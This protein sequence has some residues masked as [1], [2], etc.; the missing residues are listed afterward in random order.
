MSDAQGAEGIL[1]TLIG[2]TDAER[3]RLLAVGGRS[4]QSL[5]ARLEL[6]LYAFRGEETRRLDLLAATH[7]LVQPQLLA[8]AA[9]LR[10]SLPLQASGASISARGPA[11]LARLL[12]AQ[13][14][15]APAPPRLEGDAVILLGDAWWPVRWQRKR[16]TCVAHAAVALLEH[17]DHMDGKDHPDLSE[18]WLY[19]AMQRVSPSGQAE[20]AA[21]KLRHAAEALRIAGICAEVALPYVDVDLPP[22]QEPGPEP[23]NAAKDLAA[24][25]A[26]TGPVLYDDLPEVPDADPCAQGVAA[27]IVGLLRAGRP[28]AI[29]IEMRR[30]KGAGQGHNNW[31]TTDALSLGLV[32]DP[33]GEET[34]VF[35]AGHAVCVVGFVPHPD[36]RLGGYFLARNSWGEGFGQYGANCQDLT[37]KPHLR[38]GYAMLSAS[39]VEEYARE[40]LALADPDECA[41]RPGNWLG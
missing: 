30:D 16:P 17:R 39:Y 23:V 22:N 38:P 25:A 11:S 12:A 4:S 28:V 3:V 33:P 36:E 15:D 14:S 18:Q 27:R 34:G 35:D 41:A 40:M 13:R 2:L 20:P 32:P 6:N 21:D 8:H 26:L 7:A 31:A 10:E 37:L 29:S 1:A 24:A 5:L 9:A 19:W